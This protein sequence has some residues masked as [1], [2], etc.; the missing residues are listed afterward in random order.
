[1]TVSSTDL[2][3]RGGAFSLISWAGMCRANLTT[4]DPTSDQTPIL[5]QSLSSSVSD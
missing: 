1:M 3:E 5:D 2:I 4:L